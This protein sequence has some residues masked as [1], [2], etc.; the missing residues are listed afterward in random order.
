MQSCEID[1]QKRVIHLPKMSL[2]DFSVK[3]IPNTTSVDCLR[4]LLPYLKRE[5]KQ[6]VIKLMSE[7]SAPAIRFRPASLRCRVFQVLK[8]RSV[9]TS[10][11]PPGLSL[12]PP[13]HPTSQP[14][15]QSH[16][17]LSVPSLAVPGVAHHSTS[18]TT[19][20]TSGAGYSSPVSYAASPAESD[21]DS[22]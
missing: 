18:T 15:Q 12:K 6:N 11:S 3:K 2:H 13:I 22:D 17:P 5:D 4:C 19:M 21:G 16:P 9:V 1:M 7:G 8:E 10:A 14:H 20:M